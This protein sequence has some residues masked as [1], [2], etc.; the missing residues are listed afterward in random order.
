[1]HTTST[2]DIWKSASCVP[3]LYYYFEECFSSRHFQSLRCTKT[4]VHVWRFSLCFQF[5]GNRCKRAAHLFYFW[6]IYVHFEGKN[7]HSWKKGASYCVR[8][9]KWEVRRGIQCPIPGKRLEGQG[10]V[11]VTC[12]VN[13]KYPTC[14]QKTYEAK[15]NILVT[16]L[17]IHLISKPFSSNI[18]STLA[19][20]LLAQK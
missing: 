6:T 9:E 13:S 5:H 18:W 19:S 16:S 20:A 12:A 14:S 8:S 15:Q 1:M 10:S 3:L 11:L 2:Y 4:L 7:G 17:P